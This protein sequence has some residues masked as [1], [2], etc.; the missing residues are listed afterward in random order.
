M[1]EQQI[2]NLRLD[3]LGFI[4]YSP[5]AVAHIAEGEDYYSTHHLLAAQVLRQTNQGRIVDIAT[6]TPGDFA[7]QIDYGAPGKNDLAWADTILHL[8]IEVRDRQVQVRDVNDLMYWARETPPD[9]TIGLADGYYRLTVASARP[10]SGIW[11]DGQ[12]VG[13]WF[14]PVKAL[15]HLAW[16]EIPSLV[17]E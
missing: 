6:G 1:S 15:P 13:L 12:R 7:L 14:E 8:G 3:G 16:D 9:Q 10:S 17:N 11:G 5:F 2:I 4:V